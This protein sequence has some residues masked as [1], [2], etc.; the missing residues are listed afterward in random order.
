M[1]RKKIWWTAAGPKLP[2][3]LAPTKFPLLHPRVGQERVWSP[4]AALTCPENVHAHLIRKESKRYVSFFKN[5]YISPLFFFGPFFRL[6]YFYTKVYSRWFVFFPRDHGVPPP[7]PWT[8]SEIMPEN[9]HAHLIRKEN[10]TY[11][12]FVFYKY[13]SLLFFFRSLV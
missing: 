13:I 10:K 6:V 3:P 2:P 7:S 11:V 8:V 9:I 4:V 1:C 5:S 12:S